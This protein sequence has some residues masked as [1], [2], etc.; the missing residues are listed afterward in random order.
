MSGDKRR[1][2][3][4]MLAQMNVRKRKEAGGGLGGG[5]GD[6]LG[7]MANGIEEKIV[8]DD[9]SPLPIHDEE[10]VSLLGRRIPVWVGL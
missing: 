4:R 9:N 6:K 3:V 5:L 1:L 2:T 10:E 8:S 7:E